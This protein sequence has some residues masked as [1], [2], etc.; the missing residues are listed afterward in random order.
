MQALQNTTP[1]SVL[2]NDLLWR[3]FLENIEFPNE[4]IWRSEPHSGGL[5]TARHCSQV[6]Q[7]W[8]DIYLGSPSIWAK[9]IDLNNL[10]QKGDN[11]RKEVISRSGQ[12][13]LWVYGCPD[14]GIMSFLLPFLRGNWPRM[15]KI[16]LNAL[17]CGRS[18]GRWFFLAEPAPKLHTVLLEIESLGE[19]I[20][21]TDHAP[22]LRRFN[23]SSH[24]YRFPTSASWFANILHVSFHATHTMEEVMQI[25]K[26]MPRLISLKIVLHDCCSGDSG[27]PTNLP[28]LKMLNLTGNFPDIVSMLEKITPSR[29]CCFYIGHPVTPD[30]FG[31][32][33]PSNDAY[34]RYEKILIKQFSSYF[35]AHPPSAVSLSPKSTALFLE[36]S[37]SSNTF[38]FLIPLYLPTLSS[39]LFIKEMTNSGSASLFREV[40]LV[41]NEEVPPA[42]ISSLGMFSS[43]TT[44]CATDDALES[45]LE[46]HLTTDTFFP[47]LTALK[48]KWPMGRRP[49]KELPAHH[50]FLKHRKAIGKPISVLEAVA[51]YSWPGLPDMDYLEEFTG[52][53]VKW[54]ISD[55]AEGSRE[56]RCGDGRPEELLFH[57]LGSKMK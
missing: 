25:L 28:E 40:S 20:V 11:W 27:I 3:I 48:A 52:L 1:I 34:S 54:S 49:G 42:V 12:A 9:L 45:I 43:L 41:Y 35:A 26:R 32:T 37:L 21:F 18:W 53:V 7:E 46:H 47:L 44:L 22:L 16:S 57:T 8:R 17:F 50:R 10:C 24:Y 51:L 19:R 56:Y 30:F 6:C 33:E 2:H 23:I 39:S 4:T 36:E 15:Q 13:L 55:S 14:D 31:P 5:V 38:Q 29:E